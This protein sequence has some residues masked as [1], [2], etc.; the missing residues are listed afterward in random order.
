MYLW[1]ALGA[2][3]V[4][5]LYRMYQ[6]SQEAGTQRDFNDDV[7]HDAARSLGPY[8]HLSVEDTEAALRQLLATGSSRPEL[9][10]LQ[11]IE[12]EIV[13]ET[14][15]RALRT[16]HVTVGSAEQPEVGHAHRRMGWDSLPEKVKAQF[17]LYN[18]D[19]LTFPVWHRQKTLPQPTA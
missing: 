7:L 3:A 13:K 2:V 19:R 15:D 5:Y 12:Y 11:K 16:V 6:G 9:G 8:F 18:S 10:V 1:I 4:W 14:A 17:L